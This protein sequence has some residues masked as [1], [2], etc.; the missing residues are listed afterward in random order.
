MNATGPIRI[1]SV[2]DHPM[3]REGIAAVLAREQ[4]MILVA[5][6]SNG[7]EAQL[8]IDFEKKGASLGP[9]PRPLRRPQPHI[10]G[11]V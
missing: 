1:L 9:P 6:A 11:K 4:D 5:E 8:W 7:R 2:D 10:L 3:L